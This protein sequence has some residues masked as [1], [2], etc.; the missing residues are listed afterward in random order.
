MNR[1]GMVIDLS[2]ASLVA[3]N[4]V[5]NI[6]KA[7]VIFSNSAVYSLFNNESNIR[8]DTLTLLVSP[9]LN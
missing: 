6:S 3:I 7:P 8:D 4:H 1:L 5:L 2:G 9:K